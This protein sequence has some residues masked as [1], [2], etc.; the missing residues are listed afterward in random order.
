MQKIDNKFRVWDNVDYMSGTFTLSDLQ[1]GKIKF[2][3]DCVILEYIGL[4]DKNG[5]EIYRG[6]IID[7]GQTVNG[8]SRFIVEWSQKRMGW[9]L[10][11]ALK[12]T[13]P[14]TYEYDVEDAFNIEEI[15]IIGHIYQNPELLY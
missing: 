7:L 2:T 3:S 13:T 14:R 8:C 10:R 1:E 5:N 9:T 11:Y 4:K 6:N 12:M 15:E